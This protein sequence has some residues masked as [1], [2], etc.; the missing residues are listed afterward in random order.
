M[1]AL[2]SASTVRSVARTAQVSS[3]LAASSLKPFTALR[4][5]AVRRSLLVRA[6]QQTDSKDSYQKIEEPVR[7]NFPENT[8][9]GA[10]NFGPK[11][12][13]ADDFLK[14][15][16]ANP[17]TEVFGTEVGIVDAMRF[18]GAAPEVIN[19]RL[20]MLG[21]VAAVAVEAATGRNVIQQAQAAPVPI[22][23]ISLTFVVASIVPIVRGVPRRGNSIFTADAELW[24][25]RLAMLGIAALFWN[26]YIGPSSLAPLS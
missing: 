17:D 21:F 13:E 3:P 7:T 25:G 10:Q 20:A 26:A 1:A 12:S 8:D 24:N 23:L 14:S 16:Q 11:Q 15:K 4:P 22:A 5:A 9:S 2:L 6:E 19:C 18:K